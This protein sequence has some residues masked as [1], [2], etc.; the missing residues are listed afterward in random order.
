MDGNGFSKLATKRNN[1]QNV[2]FCGISVFTKMLID[3]ALYF[4][5]TRQRFP[6]PLVHQQF[7]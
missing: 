5:Q 3:L 6:R 4:Y 2:P 1:R 7:Y